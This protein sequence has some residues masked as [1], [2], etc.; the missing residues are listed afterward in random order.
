MRKGRSLALVSVI[1]VAAV[2]LGGCGGGSDDSDP[3]V[4]NTQ[5]AA[6]TSESPVITV[7]GHGTVEGTPDVLTITLGVSTHG[8]AA[9]EALDTNNAR[10]AALIQTL[11]DGG[12]E[13]KDIQTSNLNIYPTFDKDGRRITGYNVDNTVTARLKNLEIAGALIDFAAGVVG[14]DIRVNGIAFSIDDTSDL[15]A[16]ARADAVKKAMDQAKQLADASDVELGDLRSIEE[17]ARDLPRPVYEQ[18]AEADVASRV[19][20]EPGSQELS[21]DVVVVYAIAG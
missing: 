2:T 12:V 9:K 15:V 21:V 10:A 6:E 7:N 20:L 5:A 1:A 11:K 8:T 18:Y 17:V 3:Q 19:P 13:S 4:L 16:A 14:D